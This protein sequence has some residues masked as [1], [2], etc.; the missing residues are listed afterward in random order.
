M[1]TALNNFNL[2]KGNISIERHR[3]E[4]V[5]KN[6][7]LAS[8]LLGGILIGS[9]LKNPFKTRFLYGA[10]LAYRGFTGKCLFYEYLGID[11]KKPQAVNIRG[12]FEIDL[13]PAEV[14]AYWRNLKNLPSTISNLL[15]VE[16]VD[17][18]LSTWKTKVLGNLLSLKW[19]AEIVK[20]EPGYLIG[21]RAVNSPLLRH[22]G[23][24]EFENTPDGS[25]TLL[26]IVLSYRPLIGGVGVGISKMINPYFEHLLKKEIKNFKYKI[27]HKT[28]V[29]LI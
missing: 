7:R 3:Y 1:K 21:W 26:K 15:N 13:P 25:G 23:R 2:K 9:A 5:G 10:Y 8:L 22:V 20:D 24:V 17:E 18:N 19:D 27:E 29:V 6:E 12:E 28:P 4:N 16:V 11:S 14:Y